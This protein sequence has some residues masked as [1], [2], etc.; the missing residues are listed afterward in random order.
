MS[1][2][3]RG[4]VSG[5][6]TRLQEGAPKG[7]VPMIRRLAPHEGAAFGERSQSVSVPR[8]VPDQLAP[9]AHLAVQGPAFSAY[10]SLAQGNRVGAL[11]RR[12]ARSPGG[13]GLA[14]DRAVPRT[15]TRG[16]GPEDAGPTR[17]PR[18]GSLYR[19]Y[20]TPEDS[21]G[22]EGRGADPGVRPNPLGDRISQ[23]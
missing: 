5:L 23:G 2:P 10:V 22:A 17:R 18:R 11:P 6:Q 12:R 9:G 20:Q 13:D 15:D 8:S 14:G 4:S 3:A 1:R 19:S 21:G 16:P 7:V